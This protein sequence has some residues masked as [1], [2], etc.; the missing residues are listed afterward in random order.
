MKYAVLFPGQGS[1]AVGMLGAHPASAI[2]PVLVEASDALGWDVLKLVREGPAEELNR[3]EK[4]Q[5][6]LLAASVALWR[7]FQL[8]D[9][10][11]PS[12]FA[13][14]S[15][16]EYSALV[17]A[18]SMEFA[19]ALKL[20]EIRGQL[21]QA[22]VPAGTGGMAA[23]IGM[24]DERVEA[25]CKSYPGD[26]VLEPV[27]YNSPGQV[28]VAG[29]T[30]ALDWLQ[31]NGK[32]M[33]ARMVMRLP[34]S[35]PSHCSLM[36]GAADQLAEKLASVSIREPMVPVYHNLDAAPR[37]TSDEIRSALKAQLFQP[38]RWTQTIRAL[39][40]AG[41]GVFLECGPGKVLTG[42]NKR[43]LD[44][45]QSLAMEDPA[46]FEQGCELVRG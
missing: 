30:A 16:G 17:A 37:N 33:G 19:D 34:V 43:I 39:G 20:V 8:R 35:V 9:V 42:L 27:N 31:A 13:G 18:S 44:A 15:L 11:I 25:L 1:Q 40:D 45:A 28:V 12:A 5:P 2:D 23:V 14:H 6:A 26:E 38:V 3:T 41:I 29:E 10:S 46:A 36:R 24:E 21:M 4:T 32:P 7:S 22:A